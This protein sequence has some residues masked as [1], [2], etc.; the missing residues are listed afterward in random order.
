MKTLKI[1]FSLK[2]TMLLKMKGI[3]FKSTRGCDFRTDFIFTDVRLYGICYTFRFKGVDS[4]TAKPNKEL[5]I[6]DLKELHRVM[7]FDK[8]KLLSHY[9]LS[10]D[11]LMKEIN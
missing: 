10:A 8:I 6:K 4:K 11:E 7:P 2:D 1:D 3:S 9:E 5:V